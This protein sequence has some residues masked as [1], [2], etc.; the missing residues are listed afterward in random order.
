MIPHWNYIENRQQSMLGPICP[1]CYFYFIVSTHCSL[2]DCSEVQIC[3]YYHPLPSNTSVALHYC[4]MMYKPFVNDA[5][6]VLLL[7][8]LNNM[9]LSSGTH[10]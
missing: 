9:D 8:L 7:L 4:Q 5:C 2:D 3:S 6:N 10:L 1:P